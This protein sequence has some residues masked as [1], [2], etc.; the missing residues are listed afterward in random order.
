MGR[1]T[2]PKWKLA[3]REGMDLYSRGLAVGLDT[4]LTRRDYPPGMHSQRR[5]KLSEYGLRLREKQKLKRIYGVRERQ[6]ERYF[7]EAVRMKGD[8]GK[9][10]LAL[11]ERRLDSAVT[12][13][14]FAR[15]IAQARQM[16]VHGHIRVSNRRVDIP[17]YQVGPGEIIEPAPKEASAKMVEENLDITKMTPIPSWMDVDRSAKK[18]TITGLPTR[19]DFPYPILES[20]VIEFY[21]R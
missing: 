15:T 5:T 1:Y 9:N 16:V 8:A 10:L 2:G 3:R 11:M 4:P 13:A 18:A 19:E 12:N 14:G 6:C 20:L 7:R 21:S 17:S